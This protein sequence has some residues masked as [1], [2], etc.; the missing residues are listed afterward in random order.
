M[1][2]MTSGFFTKM[3][4][5]FV[6]SSKGPLSLRFLACCLFSSCQTMESVERDAEQQADRRDSAGRTS[7]KPVLY[8]GLAF[9]IMI[10][11]NMRTNKKKTDREIIHYF[12]TP[13]MA[14][15]KVGMG[16]YEGVAAKSMVR[17]RND[18]I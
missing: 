18:L 1:E 12:F 6:N 7:G 10:P 4:K 3:F 11:S 17:M 15:R 8:H 16:I 14:S 9:D 13:E 5:D 2:S